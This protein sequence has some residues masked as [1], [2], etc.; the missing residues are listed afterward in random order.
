MAA[1]GSNNTKIISKSVTAKVLNAVFIKSKSANASATATQHPILT[2][3]IVVDAIEVVSNVINLPNTSSVRV[4][5]VSKSVS[6][7]PRSFSPAPKSIAG[8]LLAF[9]VK[10]F[11]REDVL[12]R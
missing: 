2:T 9:C 6:S 8:A 5:G 7:V 11:N 10:W 12:F 4:M 3:V 1:N